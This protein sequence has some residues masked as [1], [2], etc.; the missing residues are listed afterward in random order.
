ML[1]IDDFTTSTQI[2]QGAFGKV[3][4]AYSSNTDYPTTVVIKQIDKLKMMKERMEIYREIRILKKIDY[5]Y[6]VKFFG[7]YE[8]NA[9]LFQVLEYL[10]NGNL[11]SLGKIPELEAL[12]YVQDI[13]H[14]L[15]YLHFNFIMHRDVKPENV[16]LDVNNKAKLIDFG[17]AQ[18]FELDKKYKKVLGSLYHIAPEMYL[19]NYDCRVDIWMLGIM[20]Y[21][22]VSGK[23]PFNG[24]NHEDLRCKVLNDSVRYPKYL[25]D[26]TV[27]NIE[28]ILVKDLSL[29]HI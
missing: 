15:N 10:P 5:E 29:I 4:R 1:N 17:F 8:D 12:K 23:V 7:F 11:Y 19:Q 26:I 13:A 20:Y 2:G 27:Q 9:M 16:V 28:K 24:E 25:E 14:A 21:E 18:K 6:I 3:Y 22:L